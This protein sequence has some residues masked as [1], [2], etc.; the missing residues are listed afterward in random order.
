MISTMVM[1]PEGDCH[2]SLNHEVAQFL[3][4]FLIEFCVVASTMIIAI[5]EKCGLG[6]E[7]MIRGDTESGVNSNGTLE[8]TRQMSSSASFTD[9]SLSISVDG[10][11]PV[12]KSGFFNSNMGLVCGWL[13]LVVAIFSVLMVFLGFY[14]RQERLVAY[15]V[16]FFLVVCGICAIPLTMHK[17][18]RMRFKD[19]QIKRQRKGDRG[20]VKKSRLHRK[21]DRNLLTVTF[22]ALLTYKMM[23]IP[24]AMDS[25]NVSILADAIASIVHG[26]MQTSFLNW[27]ACQKRAK[28]RKERT[29]KPGRQFLEFLRM[30]N[31]SLWL[32]NTFLLK[33]AQAK[34]LHHGTFGEGTWVIISNILQP[35]TILYY[36]HSMTCVAEVIASSYTHKY[37][38]IPRANKQTNFYISE[39]QRRS[40]VSFTDSPSEHTYNRS[41][42]LPLRLWEQWDFVQF[43]TRLYHQKTKTSIVMWPFTDG[44]MIRHGIEKLS[45]L[46]VLCEV[47]PPVTSGFPSQ[48][49]SN[50]GLM[51]YLI[52]SWTSWWTNSR[53]H[54]GLSYHGAYVMSL[55]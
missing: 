28:S 1:K 38:G 42:S 27:Y 11:D 29:E 12:Q 48:M 40:V 8:M 49:V 31:L 46:L 39:N 16:N 33:H 35:L 25:N 18:S 55:W 44:H 43:V 6:L 23:S 21:M 37:V 3:F 9:E 19:E 7:H 24:V 51:F 52:L 20:F 30:L 14:E 36:F 54:R 13:S 10:E 5:W 17:M 45:A 2:A 32:V 41:T 50:W 47:N 53:V 15:A 4:P 22:L 34:D 26:F